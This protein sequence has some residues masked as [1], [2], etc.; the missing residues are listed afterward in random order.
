MECVD[1]EAR[2]SISELKG[3]FRELASDY[4][5]PNKTNGRRSI[6]DDH[7]RRIDALETYNIKCEEGKNVKKQ[8]GKKN[9]ATLGQ[10]LTFSGIVLSCATSFAIALLK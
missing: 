6:I 1:N 7:E 9:S 10:W 4:W 3:A 2:D 8:M 5:G